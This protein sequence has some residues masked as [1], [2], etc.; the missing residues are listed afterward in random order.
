MYETRKIHLKT[1]KSLHHALAKKIH[2]F[3]LRTLKNLLTVH[4]YA[5]FILGVGRQYN[6]L[7]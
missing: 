1:E 7:Q 2:L 5:K 4:L 6:I 3:M